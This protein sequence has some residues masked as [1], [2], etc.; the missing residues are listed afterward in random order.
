MESI[1]NSASPDEIEIDIGKYLIMLAGQWRIV[2]AG[3]LACALI[4]VG[5][6]VFAP[7]PFE[8]VSSAAIIS[9]R[10]DVQF[11]QRI[12]TLSPDSSNTAP[13]DSRRNALLGLVSNTDIALKTLAKFNGRI[14]PEDADPARMLAK[15]KSELGSKGDLILIKVQDRDPMLAAE[16]ATFWARSYEQY[17][18]EIYSGTPADYLKSVKT[19]SDRAKTEADA[20]QKA[21]EDFMATSQVESLNLKI[22]DKLRQLESLQASTQASS[23]TELNR[24]LSAISQVSALGESQLRARQLRLVALAML[25]QVRAGGDAAAASNAVPVM[26]LKLQAFGIRGFQEARQPSVPKVEAPASTPAPAG[27]NQP[28]PIIVQNPPNGNQ[29]SSS[30]AIPEQAQ[31]QLQVAVPSTPVTADAQARDL[32]ALA[33]ALQ[34]LDKNLGE[35]L[36]A[37]SAL[38]SKSN[39]AVLTAPDAETRAAIDRTLGELRDARTQLEREQSKLQSL[40]EQRDLNRNTYNSLANKQAEVSI[41]NAVSNSEVRFASEAVAPVNRTQSRAIPIVIGAVLGLFAALVYALGRGMLAD[42]RQNG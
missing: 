27:P 37:A 23:A 22:G 1:P 9:T 36:T 26:Q 35:Q 29:G 12:R 38:A 17:I 41:T 30:P 42:R 25:D 39:Q 21:I 6:A 19:E 5:V 3:T 13:N 33:S 15:V 32:E 24:T 11:D 16:I 31:I 18:N 10:T 2:L 8:A 7:A 14:A 20:S 40:R 4:G 34:T 28:A